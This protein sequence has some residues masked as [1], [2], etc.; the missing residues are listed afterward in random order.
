MLTQ[1]DAETIAEA[2]Y[3]YFLFR[4]ADASGLSSYSNAIKDIHN[5]ADFVKILSAFSGSKEFVSLRDTFINERLALNDDTSSY[6]FPKIVNTFYHDRIL[7]SSSYSPW[8][9]NKQFNAIYEVV[10]RHTLVDEYRLW[11][12]FTLALQYRTMPGDILEVGVFKGGTAGILCSA[13]GQENTVY[14]AD[15]FK[16]VVKT[17]KIDIDYCDGKHSDTSLDEVYSVLSTLKCT[18]YLILPGIFP[19]DTGH[20]VS[21][22]LKFIH[23]DVDIYQSAKDIVEWSKDRLLNGGIIIFDDYGF[24][25]TSGITKYCEELLAT[26]EFLMIHNLNGHALF[27]K[28]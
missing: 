15:T 21:K 14:L 4:K 10:K 9:T 6:N 18:N 8:K 28:R 13:F 26:G 23:I 22:K 27:I 20:L 1:Q 5:D 17:S 19:D 7:V 16:G 11:E 3:T 24:S 12:L 2:L 25:S